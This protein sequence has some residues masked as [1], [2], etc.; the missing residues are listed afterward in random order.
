VDINDIV[1]SPRKKENIQTYF[2]ADAGG[3]VD[4]KRWKDS[5][6]GDVM[7]AAHTMMRFSLLD[8]LLDALEFPAFDGLSKMERRKFPVMSDKMENKVRIVL[9]LAPRRSLT[10]T[11][12]SNR[13][14]TGLRQSKRPSRLR[15]VRNP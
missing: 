7:I 1:D 12:I 13:W 5:F 9:Y 6:S 10:S 3:L 11:S 14:K 8:K 15:I 2:Q 4:L